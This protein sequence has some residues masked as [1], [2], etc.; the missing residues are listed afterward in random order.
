VRI[1]K[2]IMRKCQA[3]LQTTKRKEVGISGGMVADANHQGRGIQIAQ[4]RQL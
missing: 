2:R 3:S 1:I 4:W